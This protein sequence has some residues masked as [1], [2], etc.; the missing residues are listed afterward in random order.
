MIGN[1]IVDRGR[2]KRDSNWQRSGFLNKL[3][4]PSEQQL[5]QKASDPECLVW[6]LWSM[7]ESAYKATT[8]KTGR[9][10]FNPRKISCTLETWSDGA[11]DGFVIY[12]EEY[13][14]RSLITPD[15]IASIAFSVHELSAPD[16]V[17]IPF[18]RIDHQHQSAQLRTSILEHYTANSSGLEKNLRVGSDKNGSPILAV[19]NL[20]QEI[21]NIPISISHHG[22]YGAFS[23]APSVH[24]VMTNR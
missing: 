24:M 1:D 7:K 8:R 15:Y 11:V 10:V 12:E 6:T 2:A 13:R 3:F 19:E 18:E 17:I 14:T 9:R 23:M 20:L 21:I 5:I 16:Q 22:R 4:T